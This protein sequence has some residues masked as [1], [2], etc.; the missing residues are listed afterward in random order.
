[1]SPRLLTHWTRAALAA[2]RAGDDDVAADAVERIADDGDVLDLV[3][4]CRV[5]ADVASRALVVMF[6]LR[7]MSEGKPWALEQVED[8][9]R[10]PE[11]LFAGRVVT[12]Y[13]NGDGDLVTALV[14]TVARASRGERAEALRS[15]VMYAAELE[16]RAHRKTDEGDIDEQ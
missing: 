12:A 11:L 1:M 3:A 15:L 13:A 6:G 5:M 2:A 4:V 16:A 9:R 7:D 14:A 10:E 8:A